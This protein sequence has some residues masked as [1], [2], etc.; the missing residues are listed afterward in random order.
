MLI[1]TE[2]YSESCQ[3]SKMKFFTKMVNDFEPLFLKMAP[4]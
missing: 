3:T 4:S 2:P 1:E